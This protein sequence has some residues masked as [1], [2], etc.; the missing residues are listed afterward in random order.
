[1]PHA[2]DR[3]LE[4][5]SALRRRPHPKSVRGL[6]HGVTRLCPHALAE[7]PELEP[8]R[9]V[10]F[11]RVGS[12][13]SRH[14]SYGDSSDT[15]ASGIGVGSRKSPRSTR[16]RIRVDAGRRIPA[17]RWSRALAGRHV[18]ATETVLSLDG[19]GAVGRD[20]SPPLAAARLLLREVL[21]EADSWN[22]SRE[23]LPVER[24]GGGPT[25]GPI[26]APS[27][28]PVLGSGRQL[29]KRLPIS[30]PLVSSD[31]LLPQ[32]TACDR[33]SR[34]HPAPLP[35]GEGVLVPARCFA[36]AGTTFDRTS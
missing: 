6:H 9:T 8:S 34:P 19:Q 4:R 31:H 21:R 25:L 10:R 17:P 22:V 5:W 29:H 16:E 15:S 30:Q 1:M 33:G 13:V 18:L 20:S 36:H 35:G 11:N 12:L 23:V 14:S 3:R 27:R 26:Q 7:V 28:D 2:L 32:E 24:R